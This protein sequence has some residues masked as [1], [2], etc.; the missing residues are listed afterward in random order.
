M[1]RVMSNRLAVLTTLVLGLLAVTAPR[2][3]VGDNAPDAAARGSSECIAKLTNFVEALDNLLESK[4]PSLF[5]LYDLLKTYFPLERCD[6]EEAVRISHRS[7]FFSSVSESRREF[8]IVFTSATPD[9]PHSGF[10]VSFGLVKASGN[11]EFPFAKV[12][13]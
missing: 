3:Q 6:V 13:L 11:S 1:A 10:Y 9:R 8:V 5:P 2:A 12:N 7:K 4:P